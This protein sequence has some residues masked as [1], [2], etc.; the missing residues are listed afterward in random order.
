MRLAR[1]RGPS[2]LF[3]C[4]TISGSPHYLLAV[5]AKIIGDLTH[6]CVCSVPVKWLFPS[7]TLASTAR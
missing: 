6:P 5:S 2:E 1:L 4:L 3:D 7:L